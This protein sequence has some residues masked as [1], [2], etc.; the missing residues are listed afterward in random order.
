MRSPFLFARHAD[1]V[2]RYAIAKD[3]VILNDG[4]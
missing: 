1:L 4:S 2:K 3:G